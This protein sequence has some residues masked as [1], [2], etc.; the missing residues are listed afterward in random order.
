MNLLGC[1]VSDK[2]FR[3]WSKLLVYPLAPFFLTD[4]V[5]QS[6]SQ[7][8]LLSRAEFIATLRDLSFHDSYTTYNVGTEA[9]WV[10]F[11]SPRELQN[12]PKELRLELLY[13]QAKLGRGQI[14]EFDEY[15]HLLS[16]SE[17]EQA[18]AFTFQYEGQT[19]LELNHT[20]WQS[21]SF[22]TQKSWL[23]N[24]V[25]EDR[26][27]CLSNTLS[28]K[29]WQVINKLYPG[30][31]QLVGF[32]DSSGPNCF[33][34]TL[35]VLFDVEK[36]RSVSSLWLQRETFL[37]EIKKYGYQKSELEI[38]TDL[39]DGSVLIWQNDEGIQH[40]CF[41][42]TNGLVLNKD[43]QTWFAP[44]QILKLESVLE[45][46]EEFEVSVWAK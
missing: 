6:L 17:L 30:I 34:T 26:P 32:V 35:A 19:M 39:P 12:F 14:Y 21:F 29:E 16:D 28:K 33:A 38:S 31:K 18:L 8:I 43:A 2:R 20:I 5:K 41:Y 3:I 11:L 44:R 46:W 27:N 7:T 36:A 10:T 1:W 13:L 22:E 23:A 24:F 4:E 45:N 25:S 37:R 15:K 9:A 40:A 42:L